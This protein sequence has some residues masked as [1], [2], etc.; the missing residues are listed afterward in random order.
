MKHKTPNRAPSASARSIAGSN[1]QNAI[2]PAKGPK[3]AARLLRST[4]WPALFLAVQAWAV[5]PDGP[6]KAETEKLC[7]Q[8]HEMAKSVSVRQ[9]RNG[10]GVTMTKMVSLGAKFSDQD[11]GTILEYLTKN[12]PAD[13]IPPVNVNKARAIQLESRL[14]LKRSEAAKILRYRKEHGDFKSIEDLKKVPGIDVAKI[15]AKKDRLV[16]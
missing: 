14:S 7:V 10:W 9:D 11:F 3:I 13:E 12:F 4:L 6:G 16:F 5:L 15:E 2:Y 1:P 8:C